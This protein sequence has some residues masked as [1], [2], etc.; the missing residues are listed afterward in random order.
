[1]RTYRVVELFSGVGATRHALTRLE[2]EYSDKVHFEYLY[3]CDIDK[4]AV[5]SYNAMWG[6]TANLGDITKV[7]KLPECDLMSWSYPCTSVSVAGKREGMVEGSGTAS[8]LGWEVLR[9]LECSHRPEWLVMENV[10]AVTHKGNL[11]EFERM[12]RKLNDLGY[13]NKYAILN[14]VDF[15]IAQNRKRCFMV[16]HHNGSVPDLPKGHGLN[17]RLKDYLEE[18]V[19]EK[20]YLSPERLKGLIMSTERERE[21]GNGF[22]FEPVTPDTE[23]PSKSITTNE[24][25]RKY[26]NF[27]Q[28]DRVH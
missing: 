1:M 14:A 13:Q 28:E 8:S 22:K 21:R 7:E 24:G 27:I 4:Y 20:Y 12:Q 11:P 9:L 16:S 6:E 15:D 5:R 10:P 23:K 25:G 19:D 18:E 3:Q 2:R 17:H 26:T